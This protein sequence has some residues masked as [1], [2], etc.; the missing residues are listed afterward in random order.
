MAS[1]TTMN[2]D[3][4]VTVSLSHPH[5][6]SVSCVCLNSMYV[7]SD[8]ESSW[9][10]DDGSIALYDI[11]DAQGLVRHV[12]A[13]R[14]VAATTT[15]T[16][17]GGGD[18]A[19]TLVLEGPS[20][21]EFVTFHPKGGTVLLAG[22]VAD[23]TLWMYHIPTAKCLQVFVGHEGGVTAGAFTPDGRWV[24]SAGQDGMCRVWAPKTGIGK[25]VFRLVENLLEE[26]KED[27]GGGL[28]C[29]AVGGGQDGQL[30]IC[31]GEDGNAIRDHVADDK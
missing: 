15:T 27:G 12:P 23:G 26:E 21:V 2:S 9:L 14:G 18:L 3:A 16:R 25:H 1:G 17:R 19:P 5:S 4:T 8:R 31:G 20:D 28:T 30:A 6:D 11:H 29:L 24:V 13:D 10:P 22:S 7:T